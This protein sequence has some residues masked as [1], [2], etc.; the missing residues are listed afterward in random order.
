MILLGGARPPLDRPA[1][2]V[3]TY[4]MTETG[5]GVVYD[6]I[7]LDGVGVRIDERDEI[8]LRGA[9]LLRCYRD[10]RHPL[11]ADGWLPTGDLGHWLDGRLV[12]EG[13]QDD[14]IKTGGEKVWPEAVE[15]VIAPM[16]GVAE[17]GRIYR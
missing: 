16:G 4:G 12:V 3:T 8:H 15:A 14:L 13:R 7:A 6:G 1:N 9:M 5:S 11:D 10:G 17:E 2:V